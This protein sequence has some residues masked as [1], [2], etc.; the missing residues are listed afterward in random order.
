MLDDGSHD[1]RRYIPTICAQQLDTADVAR[2]NYYRYTKTGSPGSFIA[3]D[4]RS[5]I[6][7]F[8]RRQ[9]RITDFKIPVK[10]RLKNQA[11]NC[12]WG[13]QEFEP[14][15]VLTIETTRC[16][17]CLE[18]K[19]FI[20]ICRTQTTMRFRDSVGYHLPFS[21]S[22]TVAMTTSFAGTTSFWIRIWTTVI[23]GWMMTVLIRRYYHWYTSPLNRIP[24]P[25]RRS[26]LVGYFWT[27]YKEPFMTPHLRWWNDL[28]NSSTACNSEEESKSSPPIPLLGYSSILGRY[29]VVILDPDIVKLV[30]TESA[31]K[32]HVRFPKNYILLRLLIGDGLVSLEG[33]K[34]GHHRRI[35]G[36]A[37]QTHVLRDTLCQSVPIRTQ[38]LIRAWKRASSG[39]VIHL[40]SHLSALTLDIIGDV[41]FSHDFRAT[42]TIE[43]WAEASA[44]EANTIH[45]TIRG[46]DQ[47]Q[48]QQLEDFTDPLIQ[49]LNDCLKSTLSTYIFLLLDL[50]WLE[51]RFLNR[52]AI[53][54]RH[55][56]NQAVDNIINAAR[57]KDTMKNDVKTTEKK[58]TSILKLLLRANSESS[59]NNKALSDEELRDETKT[60]I[61]AGHET[62]STWCHW[63]LY[64]LAKYPEVQQKLFDDVAKHSPSDISSPITLQQVEQMTY[65][66]AFLSEVLRMY[67]PIPIFHRFTSQWEKFGEYDIPP[68]TR[69]VIPVYLLHHHP[70]HW[71]NPDAFL[72]ERWLDAEENDKRNRFSF[73][74]FSAG[75]RSCIGQRFAEIEARMIVT[76][77]VREFAIQLA[78]CMRDK[79]INLTAFTILRAKPTI[80][81]CV[82]PRNHT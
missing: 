79:E 68:K 10:L 22:V 56:L 40:A 82:K 36:P 31:S 29:N 81:I 24:G 42:Q 54:S 63:A 59:A 46:N 17:H 78:P 23:V 47:Q 50:S 73:L 28:R 21:S 71:T 49:S 26:F 14:C 32:E 62:T 57:N 44:N 38:Q 7:L 43:R 5:L 55:L 67:P 72:P 15:F 34:W 8:R 52:N 1:P 18:R 12:Q 16:S 33:T 11:I 70:D 25:P 35:I 65:L 9:Y 13:S 75:G 61:L 53:R 66:T 58:G 48:S 45:A 69:I 2:Q 51:Q 19:R 80:Q 6:F 39:S 41:A 60:F 3:K 4:I 64:A 30:L 77:I 74:P 76:N 27:I 20:H 37:F